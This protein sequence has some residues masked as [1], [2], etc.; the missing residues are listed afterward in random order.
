MDPRLIKQMFELEDHHWWF[1]GRRQ[2]VLHLVRK[3]GAAPGRDCE[4]RKICDLGVG[5]GLLLREL[6]PEAE[7]YGLD[8][9]EEALRAARQRGLTNLA[10]GWLPDQVPYADQSFDLVLLL[11]VLE[12]IEEDRAALRK[13]LS[14]LKDDGILICTVP[15]YQFLWSGHDTAHGHKRRYTKSA[16]RRLFDGLAVEIKI[17]SYFNTIL[18]P[19]AVVQRLAQ[20]WFRGGKRGPE[21]LVATPP[22]PINLLLTGIFAVERYLL[23]YLPLPF[24]LS[25][26]CLVRKKPDQR[27]IDNRPDSA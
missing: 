3:Y 1:R 20:K 24:G 27:Q 8:Q 4:R 7:V 14:L 10:R 19:P 15:A 9:S 17:L 12:H 18:F 25:L 13:A 6:A 2:I 21:Q 26:L 22:G 23:P 11:D 16:I 5:A